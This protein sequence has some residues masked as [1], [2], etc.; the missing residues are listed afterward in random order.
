[1]HVAGLLYEVGKFY[2]RTGLFQL[3][4]KHRAV[5]FS[6]GSIAVESYNSVLR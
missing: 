2:E 5:A 1:M 3:F 4:L 6:S